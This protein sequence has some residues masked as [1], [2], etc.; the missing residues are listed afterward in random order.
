MSHASA[1][2]D[3]FNVLTV[4]ARD[5]DKHLIPAVKRWRDRSRAAAV[6]VNGSLVAPWR[7]VLLCFVC[8]ILSGR[9]HFAVN[10]AE[11]GPN[12]PRSPS[13]K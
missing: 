10:C 4:Q 8:L 5:T 3:T 7:M 1:L 2:L 11:V 12:L 13:E 6:G 9:P